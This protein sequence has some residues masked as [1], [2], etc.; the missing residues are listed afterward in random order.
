MRYISILLIVILS[1]CGSKKPEAVSTEFN[2]LMKEV[3]EV[4]DVAMAEM[5]NLISLKKELAATLDSTE[6]D[7]VKLQAIEDLDIAHESMMV[8]MRGFSD[9]FT[10]EQITKGLPDTYESEEVRAEAEET[11]ID[12]KEQAESVEEMNQKVQTSLTQARQIL[13]K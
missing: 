5:G 3:I 10:A 7:S 9:A 6:N 8:W 13:K 12:L 2:Q 4:H 1:A 11:L